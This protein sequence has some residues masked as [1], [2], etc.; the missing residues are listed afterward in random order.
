MYTLQPEV[1]F[2]GGDK[3]EQHAQGL[4]HGGHSTG[5]SIFLCHEQ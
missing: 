2:A 4:C 1:P 3:M 5:T